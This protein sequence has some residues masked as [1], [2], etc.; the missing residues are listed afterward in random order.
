M[1]YICFK[2]LKNNSGLKHISS[3]TLLKYANTSL[4]EVFNP[5]MRPTRSP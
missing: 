3:F 5:K 1:F 4:K 2:A